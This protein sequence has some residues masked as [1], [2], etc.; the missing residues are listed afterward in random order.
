VIRALQ[1]IGW[2]HANPAPIFIDDGVVVLLGNNGSGKSSALD[3]LKGLLGVRRFG[4]GRTAASYRFAGRAGAPAA[5]TAYVLGV[6]DN[7]DQ[8]GG[9]PL[10]R[11]DADEVT[12]VMEVG[13]SQ[14]RYLTIEGRRLLD[15]HQL[16]AEIAK[17]RSDRPRS[18]WMRP[19]EYERKVLEPLGVGPAVRRLLELPQGEIQKS[20]DRDP[21]QLVG[22][23]VELSGGRDAA[24]AFARAQEAVEEA[25]QAHREARSRLNARLARINERRVQVERDE[26]AQ[27]LRRQLAELRWQMERILAQAPPPQAPASRRRPAPKPAPARKPEPVAV[28]RPVGVVDVRALR[29]GGV[30]LV[31]EDG[32]IRVAAGSEQ[33]ARALLAP[34]EVLLTQRA[35]IKQLID[36]GAVVA[37][38]PMRGADPAK[39][40]ATTPISAS[41][42]QLPLTFGGDEQAV[43]AQPEPASAVARDRAAQ[44]LRQAVRAL[45][46]AGIKPQQPQHEDEEEPSADALLGAYRALTQAGVPPAPSGNPAQRA[47]EL[48]ELER[49]AQAE[50]QDLQQRAEALEDASRKLAEARDA[51]QR[52]V[53]DALSGA[54]ERFSALCEDAGL[55]GEMT[56]VDGADG[57][58]VM[59]RAAEAPGEELR[60]LW[61]AQAS[62]SGGWRASVVVLA[63]LACLDAEGAFRVLLLDEV[64]ASLDETRMLELGR[65]FARL[66]ERRGLQTIMTL[67]TKQQAEVAAQ[68]AHQQIGFIRPL[69]DEALAPPPHIISRARR[70][71]AAA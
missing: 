18:D 24:D 44:A 6:F 69:P 14:R 20:L 59:I 71:R 2:S 61:G 16:P 62:L 43:A 23:L 68:F 54:A 9:R 15:V 57:P 41:A 65:S 21:R 35:D 26:R 51:Y 66:H 32:Y 33:A 10:E 63:M 7:A 27:A 29:R 52:A 5:R 53:M 31:V 45:D 42:N 47:A 19:S 11:H 48:D 34:G 12:V 70:Q 17:L 38:E 1:M 56:V 40:R 55:A 46:A 50:Q 22:L 64:G 13:P 36:S 30:R 25:R 58:Q 3:A 49:L 4:Q 39:E 28:M 8:G 37:A 60:P 67:P